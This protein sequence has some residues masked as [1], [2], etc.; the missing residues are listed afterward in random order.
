MPRLSDEEIKA[1]AD[2]VYRELVAVLGLKGARKC[3]LHV[4]RLILQ[5]QKRRKELD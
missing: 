4:G 5:E 2:R 1:K 3:Q